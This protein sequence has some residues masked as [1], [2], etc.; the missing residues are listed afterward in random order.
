M[1]CVRIKRTTPGER[2]SRAEALSDVLRDQGWAV[3]YRRDA[4]DLLLFTS[5]PLAREVARRLKTIG[6]LG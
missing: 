2:P 3:P 4:S 1:H 6:L 5:L